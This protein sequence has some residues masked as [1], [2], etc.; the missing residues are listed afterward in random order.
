MNT[1]LTLDIVTFDPGEACADASAF[2]VKIIKIVE[3]SWAS[4]AD[5]VLLPEFTWLGLATHLTQDSGEQLPRVAEHFRKEVLP[6]LEKKLHQPGKA[7]VIGTVPFALQD[8]Q[9]RNRA[10]ILPMA[11]CFIRTSCT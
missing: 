11:V 8:G 2:A 10:L 3:S 6:L 9:I 7:A 4:G 1:L 5:L